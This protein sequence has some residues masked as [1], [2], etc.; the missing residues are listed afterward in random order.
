VIG[1]TVMAS[2]WLHH[3]LEVAL[4]YVRIL[5]IMLVVEEMLN[6]IRFSF[7]VFV[8]CILVSSW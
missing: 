3:S 4:G 2:D 8:I 5:H 6:V 7:W 1:V